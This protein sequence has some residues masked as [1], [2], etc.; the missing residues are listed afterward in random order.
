MNSHV[1]QCRRTLIFHFP[2][3]ILTVIATEYFMGIILTAGLT[4]LNYPPA[5]ALSDYT[6]RR[7]QIGLY[8]CKCIKVNRK[9]SPKE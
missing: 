9:L 6:E 4:T 1:F 7:V 5:G 2:T 8:N 3:L